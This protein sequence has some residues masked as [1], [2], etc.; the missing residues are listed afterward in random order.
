MTKDERSDGSFSND[1]DGVFVF[2]KRL[3]RYHT[4]EYGVSAQ[5]GRFVDA[6][7]EYGSL[8]DPKAP[9]QR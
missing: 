4:N 8:Q 5:A 1:R 3:L 9:I 6:S 2:E 7:L